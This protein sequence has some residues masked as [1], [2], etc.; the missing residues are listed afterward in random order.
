MQGLFTNCPR[1]AEGIVPYKRIFHCM[2]G[3]PPPTGGETPPLHSFRDV[4]NTV[5]YGFL[6]I[7]FT[8]PSISGSTTQGSMR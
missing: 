4:V 6:F 3:V 8:I 5:T 2:E 1:D 7:L